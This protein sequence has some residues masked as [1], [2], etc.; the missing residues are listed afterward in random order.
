MSDGAGLKAAGAAADRL[1]DGRV[2]RAVQRRPAVHVGGAED[3]DA[4]ALQRGGDVRDAGVI[5]DEQPRAPDHGRHAAEGR[6][7]G[8]VDGGPGHGAPHG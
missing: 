8:E 1:V 5:G 7:A 6:A 2:A 3:D 4:G